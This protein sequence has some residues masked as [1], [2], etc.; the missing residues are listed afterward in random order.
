MK[1]PTPSVCR[2]KSGYHGQCKI[3]VAGL[4]F[5]S[6]WFAIQRADPFPEIE[7]TR[8]GLAYCQLKWLSLEADVCAPA[9]TGRANRPTGA[10]PIFSL[11]KLLY[12]AAK[13]ACLC[14]SVASGIATVFTLAPN[15]VMGYSFWSI[16]IH[17]GSLEIISSHMLVNP[18]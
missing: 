16:T 6:S 10:Q 18:I 12:F 13:I 11:A 17:A 4:W 3:G 14:A 9:I 15:G 5:S 2:S 1:K 7:A 8:Y